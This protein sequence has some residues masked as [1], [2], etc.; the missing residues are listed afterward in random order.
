MLI[1]VIFSQII[2]VNWSTMTTITSISLDLGKGSIMLMLI[3]CHSP[4]E[5]SIGVVLLTSSNA[6]L[7]FVDIWNILI[8]ISWCLLLVLATSSFVWSILAFSAV[9]D[10][11]HPLSYGSFV[12]F[13]LWASCCLERTFFLLCIQ[14]YLLLMIIYCLFPMLRSLSIFWC[15]FFWF[16]SIF[17]VCPLWSSF[18]NIVTSAMV[19]FIH[20]SFLSIW[21]SLLSSFVLIWSFL[22]RISAFVFVLPRICRRVKS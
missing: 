3:S 1:V 12:G 18:F 11:P 21:I 8:Y 7:Y 10:V 14:F 19:F 5:I 20:S 13:S 22:E 2:F 16:L 17:L 4:Y 9:L 15:H 6:E